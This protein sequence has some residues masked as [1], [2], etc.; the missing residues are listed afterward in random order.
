MK[1]TMTETTQIGRSIPRL[2]AREK[3]SG[4]AEYIHNLRLPGML[5]GK[6]FRSTLAHGRI[7][8]IDVSAAAAV[9]GVHRVITAEDVKSVIPNPYYGPIFHD[10]PILAMD[11]VRHVGESVAVVLAADPHV[12]EYA[13]QLIDIEYEELPPV[14]D[15]VAAMQSSAPVVHEVLKPAG[16]FPDF[17]DLAGR[18][19]TNLH[20]HFKLRRGDVEAAFAKADHVLEHTF[21]TT[22]IMH[23]TLEPIVTVAEATDSTITLYTASQMVSVV[24]TEMARLLGWPE[25][26]VRVKTAFL[27]GGFGAKTYIKV[28]AIAAVCAMLTRLPVKI[29]LSMEEQFYTIN[30]HANTLRLKSAVTNDGR[31]TARLCEIWWNGGAYADIGPRLT[32]KTGFT[33]AGPYDIENVHI[34]SYAVYTHLPPAAGLRGFGVPTLTFAY[35]SHTDLIARALDMDPVEFRRKNLLREGRPQATGTI[36]KDAAIEA[37]LDRLA[38]RM[39]WKTPM[40]RGEGAIRRGRGIGIGFKAS[41]SNTTS[42][43]IVNVYGDG[44]CSVYCNTV[45]MGQG[46]DTAMAQIAGEVLDIPAENLKVVHPDTDVTPYDMGTLGSRSTFH[47]GQAV[48]MAAEDARDKLLALAKELGVSPETTPIRD[49]FRQR[50]GMQAGNIVGTATFN[51][52]SNQPDHS[53]GLA[54]NITPNWMIGGTGAEVEVDTETGHVRV[55][56]LVTVADC[57][58]PINPK[59]VESQLSGAA[60]MQLGCTMSEGIRFDAGQATNASLA[61]YKI[62]GIRDIPAAFVNEIVDARQES[63]PF[64]AKGVGETGTFGVSAAIANAIHDAVGVRITR[65]PITPEAV[66]DALRARKK[67]RVQG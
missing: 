23:A 17:K 9:P 7:K 50:Y 34:D 25:N 29:A 14:F 39:S 43:A 8:S 38:A 53:T 64:G 19:D 57:G 62:P 35:E 66:Y 41:I 26:R 5:Y 52:K 44:S 15:E 32:Q 1:K 16:M 51:P 3:V 48:R 24:R 28:E 67:E 18:R 36:M 33:G 42:V 13:T 58:T 40:E 20:L 6:V 30:K 47:M 49:L 22:Q 12:A 54:E 21:N 46:S 27:G 63:G 60:T 55:T 2:E 61:D 10:Q 45:D 59:I 56:K 4:R 65:L 31:V 11:K 37:V